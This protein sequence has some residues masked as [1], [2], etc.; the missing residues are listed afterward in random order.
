MLASQK[1]ANIYSILV[2][3]STQCSLVARDCPVLTFPALV[4]SVQ[5]LLFLSRYI[6][7]VKDNSHAMTERCSAVTRIR[8][9]VVSA[10]TR[11]TNH[12][13][14]TARTWVISLKLFKGRLLEST[15]MNGHILKSQD[16]SYEDCLRKG[17]MPTQKLTHSIW[18]ETIIIAIKPVLNWLW[19]IGH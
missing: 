19:P 3:T 14:I 1:T 6:L 11:S 2:G 10:T 13:T 17:Q 16:I 4:Q 9:W 18:R 15:Q 5:Q 12:Y 7:L 8:T